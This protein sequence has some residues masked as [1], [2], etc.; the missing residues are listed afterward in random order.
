MFEWE[1]IEEY[2]WYKLYECPDCYRAVK[3]KIVLKWISIDWLK[4]QIDIRNN[5][6][7]ELWS[8]E[9]RRRHKWVY[10]K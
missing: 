8:K 9:E 6:K 1:F 3:W 4:F 2:G 5:R 10:M 7:R